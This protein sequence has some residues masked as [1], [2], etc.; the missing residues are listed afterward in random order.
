MPAPGTPGHSVTT[1]FT[2]SD[3]DTVSITATNTATTV[4]AVAG[5]AIGGA[6]AD[7]QVTDHTTITPFTGVTVADDASQIETVTVT[8]SNALDGS[9]SNLGTGSYD[10]D[11]GVYTTTGSASDVTADLQGLVF[12]PAPRNSGPE[13]HHHLHHQ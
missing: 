6:T 11:A 2:I 9:L 8:L 10:P 1:T 4:T 5:P 3:T 7:Q 13:R 12:M